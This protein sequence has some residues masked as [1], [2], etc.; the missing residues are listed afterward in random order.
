MNPAY[1]GAAGHPK[2]LSIRREQWQNYNIPND[3]IYTN[4]TDLINYEVNKV[5]FFL[6]K[7]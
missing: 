1:T 5:D 2:F 3:R 7:K 4:L 6:E